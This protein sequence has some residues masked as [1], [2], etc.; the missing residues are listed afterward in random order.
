[1]A[2]KFIEKIHSIFLDFSRSKCVTYH[3]LF[4][5][6]D[7]IK[8]LKSLKL[9]ETLHFLIAWNIL[10]QNE[11]TPFILIIN[12]KHLKFIPHMLC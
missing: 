11:L 9:R 2:I 12:E 10:V 5:F 3:C 8:V 6:Q 7:N 4:I 1:M